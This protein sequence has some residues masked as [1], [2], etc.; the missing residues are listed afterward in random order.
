MRCSVPWTVVPRLTDLRCALSLLIAGVTGDGG[1]DREIVTGHVPGR[2]QQHF[3]R[4]ELSGLSRVGKLASLPFLTVSPSQA[5]HRSL[6][7]GFVLVG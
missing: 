1:G 4:D 5:V 3:W 2:Q 6:R 7:D